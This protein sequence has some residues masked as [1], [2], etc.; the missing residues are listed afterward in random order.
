MEDPMIWIGTSGWVYPHW[1]GRFYPRELPARDQ[2]TYY[3]RHFA[4]VEIN[5]SFYRLPDRNQFA[6][7]AEEVAAHP[8]FCCAVK[9]SRYIT[10]LKKLH[11]TGAAVARL[12]VS[13]EGL[14]EHLGPFL[15]QLPPHWRANAPRLAQFVATLPRHYR[16]AFEFRDPTWFQPAITQILKD[17][18]CALVIAIGGSHP[19]PLDIATAGPFHYLRFHHGAHD[20][21]FS[22]AELAFWA[23]RLAI[24]DEQG[25]DAYVYF[26]NDAEGHAITDALRLR[27]MLGAAAVH[28]ISC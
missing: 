5:R 28:P 22:D 9:A 27:A 26:N 4:T 17:A 25:H 19:T 16:A 14:S 11:D 7:W 24:T 6:S 23:E 13:A 20:I 3:A 12:I 21:G 2:L 1:V 10:H 15:Y 8:G 18:G